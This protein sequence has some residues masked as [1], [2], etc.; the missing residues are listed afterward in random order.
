MK[1]DLRIC[2]L[3]LGYVGLPLAIKKKKK[4]QVIG[5][6]INSSRIKELRQGHDRTKEVNFTDLE[7][8]GLNLVYTSK[9]DDIQNCDV[10]IITVP[11]PIDRFNVPDLTSLKTASA[12]VSKVLE[13][14][15]IVI[16]ESTVFPGATDDICIPIIERDTNLTVNKDFFAGYSPERI[17]PGDKIN[18]IRTIKKI[19]S[20]SCDEAL[21]LIDNLYL[22][23][24]DAGTY[25]APS[26]KVAE[27]AKVIE[28][29][30]RDINIALMNELTQLFC[31]MDINTQ[32]VLEA[33][34]TKWNFINF[35]PGLVGGHCIGVDPYYLTHKANEY[36]FHP[37]IIL[38]GRR[39][40]DG[41][42]AFIGTNFAKKIIGCDRNNLRVLVMG[43]T[44][45]ENC[46]DIRNTKVNDL[47][48][49]LSDF[50]FSIDVYDPE[51]ETADVEQLYGISL[52]STVL[53]NFY[54]GIII[55]VGHQIFYDLGV[56]TIKSYA[57]T[58]APILDL[59]NL[60]GN[61]SGFETL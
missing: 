16:Y 27:A 58:D 26:I 11:T 37:E 7:K 39:I 6:D 13:P 2:V 23:I 55:A 47:V 57:K 44:F 19:V 49:N 24:I 17:N 25:R 60:F 53:E 22:E 29:T 59:K 46:P 54:S 12:L 42:A 1:S 48:N 50:G 45:K 52:V 61:F 36:N 20:G 5:F 34:R 41:M 14:G 21:E 10:Y 38:S 30:Q 8:P 9:I 51:C 32:Q 40:N 43:F 28:N 3:G 35:A 18:T 4:R 31:K 33:A 15:N 56:E